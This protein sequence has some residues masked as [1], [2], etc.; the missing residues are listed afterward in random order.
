MRAAAI[1]TL[2]LTLLVNASSVRADSAAAP[3]AGTSGPYNITALQGGIGMV[4][5]LPADT[6][7]LHAGA[8]W[9]ITSWV[10]IDLAQQGPVVLAAIGDVPL[11]LLLDSGRLGLRSGSV[12]VS[13]TS[14]PL[15]TGSWRAIAVTCDGASLRLY[16]GG[17]QQA[18]ARLVTQALSPLLQLAP[19]SGYP[20]SVRHFGGSLAQFQLHDAALSSEAVKAIAAD[21]PAF[22]LLTLTPLGVGWP[23]QINAWIGLTVPQDPW[24]LPHSHTPAG[25]PVALP[26]REEPALSPL[27]DQTWKLGAMAHDSSIRPRRRG[28][29]R[30]RLDCSGGIRRLLV[31]RSHRARHSAEHVDRPRRLSGP[32]LRSQ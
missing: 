1:A 28:R 31:V 10:R 4:R 3:A 19:V 14:A 17:V 26:A 5:S 2:T 18:E 29:G 12:T 13:E 27:R 20:L 16:V 8:P 24:T 32:G 23:V 22:D 7:I 25:T 9:S 21:P 15:P 30:W 11:S 6:S